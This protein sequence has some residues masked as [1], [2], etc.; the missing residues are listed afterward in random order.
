MKVGTFNKHTVAWLMKKVI[1]ESTCPG[2]V[3]YTRNLFSCNSTGK[4]E[5]FQLA[6]RK[7]YSLLDQSR[8]R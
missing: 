1:C 7:L 2:S 6:W 3:M 4:K 5:Q 8:H